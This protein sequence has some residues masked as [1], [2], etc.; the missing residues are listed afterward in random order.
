MDDRAVKPEDYLSEIDRWSL[1]VH[2]MRAARMPLWAMEKLVEAI[3]QGNEKHAPG[4]YHHRYSEKPD[5]PLEKAYRH[6]GACQLDIDGLI[7]LN[8][9]Q[10]DVESGKLHMAKSAMNLLIGIEVA[11]GA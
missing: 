1:L 7:V 9:H 4:D 3:E 5:E 10:V 2:R 6:I 11:H 8:W